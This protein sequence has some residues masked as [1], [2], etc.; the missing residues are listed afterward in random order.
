MNMTKPLQSCPHC[1]CELAKIRSAPQHR[2]YFAVI[3]ALYMHWPERHLETG[4]AIDFRPESEDQLRKWLQIKAGY[5]TIT[6]IEVPSDDRAIIKL[7]ML[8]A[9]GVAKAAK[10]YILIQP[11]AGGLTC[12]TSKSISYN[13]LG[14]SEFTKLAQAVEEVI[15]IET[16]HD[17]SR[18]LRETER[19][20]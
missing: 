5:F 18:L 1:G 11:N 9:E 13:A 20:A 7:A 12:F 17:P 3:R 6:S 10:D 2:R 8:A 15:V 19:A 14:H 16:G 4:W